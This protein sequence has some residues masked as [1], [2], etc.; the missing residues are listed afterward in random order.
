[1]IRFQAEE[2]SAPYSVAETMPPN[3]VE[4]ENSALSFQNEGD[5]E[6]SMS[7]NWKPQAEEHPRSLF[8]GYPD[9]GL[10][11]VYAFSRAES[12]Y[13][14][15]RSPTHPSSSESNEQQKASSAEGQGES[16]VCPNCSRIF[17]PSL[18][19]CFADHFEFCQG[20]DATRRG[21]PF[22]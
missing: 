5:A 9:P 6:R 11:T 18:R 10:A 2:V 4:H 13:Q 17:P 20:T 21:F 8:L 14:S 12:S 15:S 16:V 19:L 1:M 22:S 7:T 3:I